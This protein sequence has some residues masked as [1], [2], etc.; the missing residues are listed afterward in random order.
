[1]NNT[2]VKIHEQQRPSSRPHTRKQRKLRIRFTLGEKL[3]FLSFCLFVLYTAVHMVSNQVKIYQTNKEIQKLEE[4]IQ[5][6][7]KQNRD[8]YVE[9]QQ[10]S[11]YERILQK[12]K[13]LGLSL[14]ENNVKVV[15]E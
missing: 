15:Q 3:L 10:L 8:L 7:Q 13:E 9:V 11:T 6:Q 2:A 14:N 5:E 1:M 4:A 12:A